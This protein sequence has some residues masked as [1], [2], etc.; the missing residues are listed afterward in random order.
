MPNNFYNEHIISCHIGKI[1]FCDTMQ[2]KKR[3]GIH[4]MQ[5][6][7]NEYQ[8]KML[9]DTGNSNSQEFEVF[10]NR[11]KIEMM[12]DAEEHGFSVSVFNIGH[13]DIH[14]VIKKDDKSVYFVYR[15]KRL[16]LIDFDESKCFMIRPIT[17]NHKGELNCFASLFNFWELVEFLLSGGNPMKW[18][19]R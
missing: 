7:Y 19:L 2:T 1:N 13:Y 9:K 3:L 12:K 14:G 5:R 6:L 11:M 17:N 18:I 4:N 10:A 16:A 8:G 15:Y